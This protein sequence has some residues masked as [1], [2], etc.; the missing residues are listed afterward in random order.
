[1]QPQVY[2]PMNL[3]TTRKDDAQDEKRQTIWQS[4]RVRRAVSARTASNLALAAIALPEATTTAAALETG[5]ADDMEKALL[6][7]AP[8]PAVSSL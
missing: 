8:T 3:R 1:M 4:Y 7:S 5:R 6:A 2:T